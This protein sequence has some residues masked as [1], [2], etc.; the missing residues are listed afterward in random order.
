MD[1]FKNIQEAE[2]RFCI[3]SILGIGKREDASDLACLKWNCCSP[4]NLLSSFTANLSEWI[5]MLA[6][7][8]HSL[9]VFGV[10]E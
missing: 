9:I 5:S 2:V 8:K 6:Q 10:K 3:D 7:T 1:R 4:P